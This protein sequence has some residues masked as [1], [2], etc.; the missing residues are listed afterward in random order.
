[1]LRLIATLE[2]AHGDQSVLVREPALE[3]AFRAAMRDDQS[4]PR[5]DRVLPFERYTLDFHA[6]EALVAISELDD[7]LLELGRPPAR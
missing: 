2:G 4:R 6:G 3:S 7:L 1:M 5:L